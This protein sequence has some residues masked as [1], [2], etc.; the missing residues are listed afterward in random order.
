MNATASPRLAAL[1]SGS[2]LRL[3]LRLDAVVTAANGAAY[4]AGASL[5]DGTLGLD[6]ALLRG[7]AA[8]LL[9]FAAIVWLVATRERISPVAAAAVAGANALWV[10]DSLALVA[11]DWGT[12]TTAGA[13]WAVMQAGV[14]GAFAALQVAGIRRAREGGA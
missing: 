3:A 9:A 13:V 5:L 11:L 6:A 4:F 12:P 1:T 2:P 8:F 7:T 14:V 10:L